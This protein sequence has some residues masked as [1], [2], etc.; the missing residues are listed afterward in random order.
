MKELAP[1]T[2]LIEEGATG[3]VV[4]KTL[5]GAGFK[6]PFSQ[7]VQLMRYALC[8]WFFFCVLC[9]LD[10][11]WIASRHASLAAKGRSQ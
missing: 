1:E 6:E 8:R 3:G 4:G 7:P 11:F 10:F 5:K 9:G 2:I